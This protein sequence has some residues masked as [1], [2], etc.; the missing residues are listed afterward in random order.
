MSDLQHL[1]DIAA[2]LL[3]LYA[4]VA[5]PVPVE[6]ILQHPK[7]NLWGEVDISQLSGSFLNVREHYSPRMSMARLLAR[8]VAYSEWGRARKVFEILKK[9]PK[10]IQIFARMLIMPYD[11]VMGLSS[12]ARNPTAMS[13]HFEVPEEDARLRLQEM[14]EQ[15]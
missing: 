12:A 11:M 2:E 1:E 14:S 8:H 9:D 6:L 5:P 13:M 7:D 3:E 4:I 15:T 10:L